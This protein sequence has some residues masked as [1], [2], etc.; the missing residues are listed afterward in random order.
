[1]IV[2]P[3][4]YKDLSN[5][6]LSSI[7]NR[8]DVALRKVNHIVFCGYSLPDAD[9]HIKYLLKRAQTNRNAPLKVT[10]INSHPG[11]KN[12]EIAQEK[13]RYTRFLGSTVNYTNKSCQE[14]AN[15]PLAIIRPLG[16]DEVR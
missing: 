13:D 14:F 4:F 10:V 7:W 16:P 12:A 15:N 2:P 9:I 11:K 8:T 5:P 1:M 3:T 6:F